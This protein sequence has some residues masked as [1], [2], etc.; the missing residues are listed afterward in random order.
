MWCNTAGSSLHLPNCW[1]KREMGVVIWGVR[2]TPELWSGTF[3]PSQGIGP[4]STAVEPGAIGSCLLRWC[5]KHKLKSF[6]GP[7]LVDC[8]SQ[9]LD[10]NSLD[11][12]LR[13]VGCLRSL[14]GLLP[15]SPHS[16]SFIQSQ[17]ESWWNNP[18]HFFWVHAR[19]MELLSFSE[20]SFRCSRFKASHFIC[21]P[22][23]YALLHSL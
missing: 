18:E 7:F 3:L 15:L 5:W 21:M 17:N 23:V 14:V 11:I 12:V 9:L 4:H 19:H 13:F 1:K 8:V 22:Y 20:L 2:V 10:K 6:L 16:N